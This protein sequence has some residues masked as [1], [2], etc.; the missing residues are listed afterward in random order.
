MD[1]LLITYLVR[2]LV[3]AEVD[4]LVRVGSPRRF[5]EID[6]DFLHTYVV[7]CELLSTRY[8]TVLFFLLFSPDI[9]PLL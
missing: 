3:Q 2:K 5:R 6:P 9:R 7:F 4:I 1:T 8:R